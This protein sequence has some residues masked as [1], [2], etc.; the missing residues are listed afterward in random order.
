M[1]E[2]FKNNIHQH[3]LAEPQQH[4]LLGVSGGI[5][6]IALFHLFRLSGYSIS[7]AHCNFN[8]RGIE[9]DEDVNF[10]EEL[11]KK[12][13]IPFLKKSFSTIEFAEIHHMSI[14]M[15][16]RELRFQWFEELNNLHSFDKIALGHNLNDEVETF[17]INLLR[18]SGLKGLHGI[19]A[20]RDYYIRPLLFASR[21][22][23][24]DFVLKNQ[25]PFREDSS[26]SS[27]KYLRNKLRNKLLP[28]IE[29]IQIGGLQQ[30]HNSIQI[31]KG[32]KEI[33]NATIDE[34]CKN[35]ICQRG[36]THSININSL[37]QYHPLETY[38]FELLYPFKFNISQVHQIL[39]SLHI[40]GK[41]FYSS[42]YELLIDRKEL[43]LKKIDTK[44]ITPVSIEEKQTKLEF[45][46]S[47]FM[48]II[49]FDNLSQI[50]ITNQTAFLDFDKL[51]F[52]LTL[53]KWQQG[54][55]FY[56]LGMNQAKKLSD[57][58][59][60]SKASV[61]EKE[62]TWLLCSGENICWVVGKRIDNRY[63]INNFTSRAYVIEVKD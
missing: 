39:Q 63:K 46:F 9:S 60:D 61:F 5:D 40:S 57:F 12:Y 31:I 45:P 3:C 8:L 4:I 59:I 34:F 32:N 15:A 47:C 20:Q 17:F 55:F 53:R 25:F 49:P 21:E 10:V 52:P 2:L 43:L 22:Q 28:L 19:S 18:G 38:L 36:K 7:V 41:T 50:P 6:S 26:N 35:L 42:E 24:S 13:D 16:A 27:N 44:E 14:Q 62:N 37:L 54:D 23:I 33:Y 30:I 29:E 1:L 51:H 58:F 11:A 56:P 48:K